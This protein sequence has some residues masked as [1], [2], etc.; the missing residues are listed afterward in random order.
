MNVEVANVGTGND[1]YVAL[2]NA[3]SAGSGVP[4]VTQME[5]YALPQ[6]SI[7]KSLA[8]LA[9]FGASELDSTF[10]PGPR[11][12]VTDGDAVYG[13]PT[14]SGPMALFYNVKVFEEAGVEVPATWDEFADAAK[15]IHEHDPNTYISVGQRRRR[16]RDVD[17][18]AGRRLPV[19]GGRH[20]RHGR[21]RRRGLGQ[22]RQE[23]AGS[24]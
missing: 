10:S 12:S 4:D 11:E 18:L 23:V 7:G 3:I 9:P 21:P 2:Q 19:Q 16:V 5:Y 24:H 8:D 17:D 20:E 15:K 22:E 13:L 14:D 6:F 1:H